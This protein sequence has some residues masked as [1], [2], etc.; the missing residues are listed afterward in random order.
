MYNIRQAGGQKKFGNK[1]KELRAMSVHCPVAG[2]TNFSH[3][4]KYR[5]NPIKRNRVWCPVNVQEHCSIKGLLWR[6]QDKWAFY[7]LAR[8]GRAVGKNQ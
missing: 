7:S 4:C 3:Q 1:E 8:P 6:K 5:N 2:P